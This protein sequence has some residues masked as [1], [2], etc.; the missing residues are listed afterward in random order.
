MR[1]L[2]FAVKCFELSMFLLNPKFV[3]CKILKLANVLL[4]I[5]NII[6]ISMNNSLK[7]H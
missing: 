1:K 5:Y 7:M 6:Y 2:G 3:L 4:Q